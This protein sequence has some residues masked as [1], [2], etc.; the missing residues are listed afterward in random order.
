[1]RAPTTIASGTVT[2]VTLASLLV[3]AT[4]ADATTTGD[5]YH[6][7]S[8]PSSS[9]STASAQFGAATDVVLR[10]D[11]DGD[12]KDTLAVRRDNVFYITNSTAGGDPTASFTFG[13]PTDEILVGDWNGDGKDTLAIR[14]GTLFLFTNSTTGGAPTTSF[15]FGATGDT[16]VVGDWNGDGK[17]TLG[18]RRGNVYSL[19]NTTTTVHITARYG[20]STDIVITGDWN[21]D[22]KDTL[23]VRRGNVNY[24]TNSS[25]GGNATI[26]AA[27]GT[28]EDSYLVGDWDGDRKDTLTVRSAT[29]PAT[30]GTGGTGGTDGT[31]LTYTGHDT[32]WKVVGTDILP[33]LY[34]STTA[35]Q[36]C[37]W[38]R[39]QGT[40]G[41]ADTLLGGYLWPM[42]ASPVYMQ[43]KATDGL[44]GTRHCGTWV[45]ARSTDTPSMLTIDDGQYRVGID[46]AVGSYKA[47]GGASCYAQTA[48][49]FAMESGTVQE[50]DGV[51]NPVVT[52][53]ST[54]A[55][56]ATEGC[57]TWVKV[58]TP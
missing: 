34:K 33:G 29:A 19:S 22:R 25:T 3:V 53:G 10:G 15:N 48:T 55:S 52:I 13:E 17:D 30:G 2:A 51:S 31:R 39:M 54:I 7:Q 11:W 42:A 26:K 40:S 38:L 32:K 1:M 45:E 37:E 18:Y 49:D 8:T 35:S 20:T 41:S 16:Y 12:G 27:Y 14:R 6:H 58:A 21:A 43:V 44:I 24:L 5:W 46:I 36:S 23:G 50:F 28:A 56:F 9:T 47:P 57:G 4:N